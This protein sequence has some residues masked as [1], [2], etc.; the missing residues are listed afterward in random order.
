MKR[1]ILI[2]GCSV[3]RYSPPVAEMAAQRRMV[4]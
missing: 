1:K 2:A 3:W 4:R